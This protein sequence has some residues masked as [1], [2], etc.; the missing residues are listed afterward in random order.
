VLHA[1]TAS[2]YAAAEA[3]HQLGDVHAPREVRPDELRY[4][5]ATLEADALLPDAPPTVAKV[6][7][8]L[9]RADRRLSPSALAEAAD[10]SPRSVRRHREVFAAL[11][12]VDVDTEDGWRLTLSFPTTEDRRAG[13]VLPRSVATDTTLGEAVDAVAAALLP[14]EEYADPGGDVYKTLL[15]PPDPWALADDP[16][17]EPWIE[18]A[19]ALVGADPP[20][21]DR[22][23]TMGPTIEQ[24][25]LPTADT[26]GQTS[27]E[28]DSE[29]R[30]HV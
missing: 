23:V 16:R 6:V 3:C 1:L 18:V 19:A 12:L 25:A 8:A 2:P 20:T 30:T 21:E 11:D 29:A 28:A 15:W 17:L 5:L 13:G 7:A 4:A 9:L 14:P 26:T 27:L 24:A 10:V 22:T